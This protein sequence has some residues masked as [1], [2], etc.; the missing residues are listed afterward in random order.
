MNNQLDDV[1]G[2]A[3]IAELASSVIFCGGKLSFKSSLSNQLHPFCILSVQLEIIT[4]KIG[5]S[6]L[7]LPDVGGVAYIAELA[8]SVPTAANVGYY[9]K[10]VA[11]KAVLRRVIAAAAVAQLSCGQNLCSQSQAL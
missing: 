9:A 11:E 2:V 10:L 1:G 4:Q 6:N 7:L 5:W 3:Y 8:S